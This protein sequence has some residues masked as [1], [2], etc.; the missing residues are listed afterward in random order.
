MKTL[1]DDAPEHVPVRATAGMRRNRGITPEIEIAIAEA[2][3]DNGASARTAS[4]LIPGGGVKTGHSSSIVDTAVAKELGRR[5]E[6]A[7]IFGNL[8]QAPE[9][10]Q[11]QF[12]AALAAHKRYLEAQFNERLAA[13]VQAFVNEYTL[14]L[15]ERRQRDADLIVRSRKGVFTLDEFRG[16]LKCLH[17]DTGGH[18]SSEARAEAFRLVNSRKIALVEE[19]EMPTEY[20]AL[21]K[22]AAEFLKR[23]KTKTV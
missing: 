18:V 20:P 11:Q 22:T 13:G 16:L 3:L 5:E 19:K 4:E 12:E 1:E 14:P 15:M 2:V 6:R 10:R 17:P 9:G 7:R 21:P 23:K 8:P